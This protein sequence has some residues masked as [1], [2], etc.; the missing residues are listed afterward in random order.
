MSQFFQLFWG[1][2]VTFS[3]IRQPI[4]NTVITVA[5]NAELIEQLKQDDINQPVQFLY[6]NYYTGV[7]SMIYNKGGNSEDVAD[8]FQE[9]VLTLVDKVKSNQFRGDSS[10]KTFMTA[11]ARNLWLHELRT[12]GRRNQREVNYVSLNTTEVDTVERPFSKGNTDT[13]KTIFESVGAVCT[14]ILIGY[15][16]DN[17][18][19]RQ[20]LE[21]FNY[22]NEQVLRN[23]KSKCM[24]KLKALLTTNI[25]LLDQFKTLCLYGE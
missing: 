7:A 19:M 24:K 9:T 12:R 14:Q 4:T 11:V 25:P 10:I 5:M 18:S 1:K 17:L 16:Y 20:L 23:R 13:M 15:Y 3:L 8:I 2:G 21:K 6:Q 22:E